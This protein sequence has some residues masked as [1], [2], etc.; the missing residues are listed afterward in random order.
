M[1]T[2]KLECKNISFSENSVTYYGKS[3]KELNFKPYS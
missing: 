3:D 2:S 1:Y